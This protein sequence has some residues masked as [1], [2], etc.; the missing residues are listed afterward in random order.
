[1]TAVD[2]ADRVRDIVAPLLVDSAVELVDV[3]HL[4]GIL[5]VTIDRPGGVDLEVVAR[6]T[7]SVSR[8]LDEA[9]PLPGR[10][11]L[12]VSSPGLERRL[13][14]PAHFKL[15]IGASVVVKTTAEVEGDRRLQGV[16]VAAD[17][18]GITVRDESSLE[19][20]HLRHDAIEGARTVFAWGPA[21][22][23]G[24]PKQQRK[25]AATR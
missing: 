13:R 24:A 2:T 18:E 8:A 1:M 11:T 7:R 6:V 16:L 23:P 21:P 10:Y 12:E 4:G 9:D 22:K 5:R 25:K 15:A 17:D 14:T 19:E 20:R 3:E